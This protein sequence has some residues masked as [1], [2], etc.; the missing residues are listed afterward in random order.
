MRDLTFALTKGRLATKTLALLEKAGI[1]CEEMKDPSSRKLIFA[2]E[3]AGVRFFR[4][5]QNGFIRLLRLIRLIRF[6]Y[7][8]LFGFR[9][10]E[11]ELISV[12]F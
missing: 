5:R 2:N 3:E 9:K 7:A 1:T 6:L 10:A 12:D 4:N 8:D 11:R